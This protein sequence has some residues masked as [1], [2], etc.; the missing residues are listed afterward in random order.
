MEI[1][2]LGSGCGLLNFEVSPDLR[3]SPA[4]P[5]PSPVLRHRFVPEKAGANKGAHQT[6]AFL[7]ATGVSLTESSQPKGVKR[8]ITELK[9]R[10]GVY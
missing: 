3:C 9:L 6:M 2:L 4:T 8:K 10:S 5:Y 7:K 1:S